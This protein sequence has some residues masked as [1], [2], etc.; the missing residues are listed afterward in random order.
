MP[1]TRVR[2]TTDSPV[3]HSWVFRHRH[4]LRAIYG[5]PPE[6]R[7]QRLLD[8][9]RGLATP[10]EERMA[11]AGTIAKVESEDSSDLSEIE[12]RPKAKRV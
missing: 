12:L 10:S 11:D 2:G 7:V 6:P 5:L 3:V 1:S 8:E 9:D 4:Q